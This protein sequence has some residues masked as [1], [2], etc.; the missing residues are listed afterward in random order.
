MLTKLQ[1]HLRRMS[2]A[3]HFQ[4]RFWRRATFKQ[5]NEVRI[6]DR[7]TPI[8]S[9][10]EHGAAA[11][12]ITCFIEDEYG[13]GEIRFPVATIIDIGANIGFLSM[14]ARAYF[15]DATIH[16]YEPNPR[17]LAYARKNAAAAGFEL[18]NEA[19]GGTAGTVSIE[20]SGDS[21]Q[22]IT[23]SGGSSGVQV[24]QIT[25]STA[26]ARLG[27]RIDLAKIDCEGA[28]WEMFNDAAAW[29]HIRHLRMEYH[30]WGKH[31]YADVVAALDR[32]GFVIHLHND[33]GEFGTVWARNA[34]ASATS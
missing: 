11:D 16:A 14:A 15:P 32:L 1:R 2:R 26:V 6:G 19:V 12:F 17:V 28:E 27:G 18:F 25:L 33:S 29:S 23:R 30:L 31:S 13:L 10:V 21:N 5:P 4:V 8:A 7:M 9:P 34:R 24:P 22:A 20:D 3:R